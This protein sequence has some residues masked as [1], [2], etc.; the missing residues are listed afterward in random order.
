MVI[1]LGSVVIREGSIEEAVQVSLE[2]VHRSRAE[3]GCHSH[4]VHRDCENP[5]RLIF[6][7]EWADSASLQQHFRVP[8]S[9]AFVQALTALA[10]EPPSMV[11]YEGDRAQQ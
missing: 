7:E 6:V 9:G 10:A 8:E 1:V 5:Q 11:I 4:S 2:H 3:P